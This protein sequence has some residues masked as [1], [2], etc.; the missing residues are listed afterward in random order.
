MENNYRSIIHTLEIEPVI[1]PEKNYWK[2]AQEVS[3]IRHP[4]VDNI[5]RK[6]NGI[7]LIINPHKL[8]PDKYGS[9]VL[10]YGTIKDHILAMMEIGEVLGYDDYIIKRLDV[11]LDNSLPYIKTAKR[12]RLLVLLLGQKLG[13][14]NNYYSVEPITLETKTIRLQNGSYSSNT[15]K[16]LEIEHYNRS[17]V[18][19]SKWSSD[20]VINRLELRAMGVHAGKRHS[21][22]QIIQNWISR[23]EKLNKNDLVELEYN[24]AE[25]I[26]SHW[27]EYR[28]QLRTDST[29]AFNGYIREQRLN[30]YT[31]RQL[32]LISN[33]YKDGKIKSHKQNLL[34]DS[35][36][37]FELFSWKDVEIEIEMV[38]RAMR[39]YLDATAV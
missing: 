29:S 14:T 24:L 22:V 5:I 23:I 19:Q 1:T 39:T 7:R 33:Q 13:M 26:F 31:H 8:H 27:I 17:Q 20:P 10:H 15:R 28:A 3:S 2:W 36:K 35:G 25:R 21:E 4:A 9:F 37:L 30:I 16:N 34:R 18:D 32:Q 38:C 12:V 11:A 6:S